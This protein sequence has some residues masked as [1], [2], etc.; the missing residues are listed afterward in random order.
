MVRISS[1]YAAKLGIKTNDKKLNKF[2]AQ[3]VEVDGH[4]FDSKLEAAYYSQLKLAVKCGEI[5]Y[6]LMQVPIKILANGQYA[7]RRYVCDFLVFNKNGTHEYVDVK[8]YE[9]YSFK[10]KKDLVEAAYPIKL[11]LVKKV[12]IYI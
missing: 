5:L 9:T 12:T 2:R 1:D 6:F 11:K 10:L 3:R 7:K 4:I 8:G